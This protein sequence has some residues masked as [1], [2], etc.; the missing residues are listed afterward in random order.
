MSARKFDRR[1]CVL[2]D[3]LRL[4]KGDGRGDKRVFSYS[5]GVFSYSDGVFPLDRLKF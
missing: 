2:S 5:D 1:S 3:D 4:S